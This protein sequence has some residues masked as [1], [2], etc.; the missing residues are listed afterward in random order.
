[1]NDQN[2]KLLERFRHY[3]MFLARLQTAGRT[4]AK[5]D[6]SG[7][8]QQTLLEAHQAMDELANL[9][10]ERQTAWLRQALTNNLADEIRR[11]SAQKRDIRLEQSLDAPLDQSMARLGRLLPAD[12]SSPSQRAHKNEQLLRLAEALNQLPEA[13]RQ[14][15]E[16]HHLLGLTL[17]EVAER[18]Q[19][20]KPAV[21]GLLHRGLK[22]L[23]E[24][25]EEPDAES[26]C[27]PAP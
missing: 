4:Q 16:W 3:L 27:D 24:L 7:I 15:V 26:A 5:V 6:V 8:V 1:M 25:L 13:Q 22:K 23:R 9:N 11:L 18:L 20:T 21:A 17:N 19:S 2:Q 14:A 12:Q 10:E